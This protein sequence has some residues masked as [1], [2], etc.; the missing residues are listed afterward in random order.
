MLFC[1]LSITVHRGSVFPLLRNSFHL[2]NTKWRQLTDLG[3]Y[4]ELNGLLLAIRETNHCGSFSNFRHQSSTTDWLL[5]WA[6][7]GIHTFIACHFTTWQ[8]GVALFLGGAQPPMAGV[9]GGASPPRPPASYA[10][11]NVIVYHYYWCIRPTDDWHI[12][13]ESLCRAMCLP[14]AVN[15]QHIHAQGSR[16]ID[17]PHSIILNV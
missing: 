1:A 10:T 5:Y 15:V 7:C 8:T 17:M 12:V 16:S 13:T 9:W 4:K 3:Q 14:G 11:V 2:R 6:S